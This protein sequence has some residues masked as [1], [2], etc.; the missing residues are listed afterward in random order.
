[1]NIRESPRVI[2][3]GTALVDF[4]AINPTQ[5]LPTSYDGIPEFLSRQREVERSAGG[6]MATVMAILSRL[7]TSG[8]VIFLQRIGL[9]DNGEF[10]R[11]QT[12]VELS[13]GIQVDID[14]P[15]GVC[16]FAMTDGAQE[17]EQW[18][19]VTFYGASDELEIPKGIGAQG[20]VFITNVNAYRR[21]AP[22]V[23]IVDALR[24][25][26]DNGNVFIFRFSGIQHGTDEKFDK[27]ELTML[28]AALPKPPDIIFANS[29]EIQYASGIDGVYQATHQAFPE[30]RLMV[31][32]NGARGSFVRFDG[33]VFEIP[34]VSISQSEVIDTTGAGDSYMGV[35]LAALFTRPSIQWTNDFIISCAEIATYASGLII[36]TLRSR[37]TEKQLMDLHDMIELIKVKYSTG[38][39]LTRGK[40]Q[41]FGMGQ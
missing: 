41:F 11:Q 20:D 1:M 36:Q 8:N 16:I 18:P 14:H 4:K 9:D 17:V 12:P 6:S 22:K 38:D 25:V 27:G 2:G 10:Y 13:N 40:E 21:F 30:S 3:V 37:L 24:E 23:Q 35:M 33:D 26:A 28:I 34:P 29:L 7:M 5:S 32:T 39:Q 19:E 15:T 31:V